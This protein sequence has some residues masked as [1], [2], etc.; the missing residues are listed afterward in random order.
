[1]EEKIFIYLFI[2]LFIYSGAMLLFL[3]RM[4]LHSRSGLNKLFVVCFF[5]VHSV[6]AC[7]EFSIARKGQNALIYQM[8]RARLMISLLLRIC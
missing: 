5:Y 2:Y 3:L 1:M 4:I 6:L 8:N 7:K